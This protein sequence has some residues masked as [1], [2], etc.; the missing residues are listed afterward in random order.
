MRNTIECKGVDEVTQRVFHITA[1][2]HHVRNHF[3]NVFF[4]SDMRRGLDIKLYLKIY[5]YCCD[6]CHIFS[7]FRYW[8]FYIEKNGHSW[9]DWGP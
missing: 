2:E 9:M 8:K 5:L 7:F 3:D 4:I 1:D 6:C